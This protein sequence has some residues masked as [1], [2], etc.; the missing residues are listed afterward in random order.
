[1]KILLIGSYKYA[2]YAEAFYNAWVELGHEVERIDYEEYHIHGKGRIAVLLNR[3]QDRYLWGIPMQRYNKDIVRRVESFRPDF[4]FL[5]RCNN[6]YGSTIKNIRAK[7][8]VFSYHNDDPFGGVPS[9][10]FYRYYKETTRHCHLNYVYRKKNIEDLRATGV[11]NAKVLLPYYMKARNFP[12]DCTKDIQVSFLGHYEPDGRD[13]VIKGLLDKVVQV[14]VFGSEWQRAPFYEQMKHIHAPATGEGYNEMI[15]RSQI[16]LVFFSKRNNDTYTRR[17]FEIPA[18]R[19][20]MLCEY[21]EDMDRMYPADE[22]AVYFRTHE[23]AVEKCLYYLE[24]ER[25]RIQI[26]ENAYRR[27]MEMGGSEYDRAKE[28][29]EDYNEIVSTKRD[30]DA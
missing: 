7:T 5:Y 3:I 9:H 21:T 25:L 22:A 24:H 12:I 28:I 1:M 14:R 11:E 15:N 27:I 19:S 16:L 6:I 2:M 23:E 13:S 20:F 17:S 30:E 29:I 8:T 4:V 10:A 26:A 18:T